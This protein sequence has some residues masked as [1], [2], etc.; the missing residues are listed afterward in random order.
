MKKPT[1]AAV[2]SAI[3]WG[4][5]QVYN[6]QWFKG[7]FFFLFQILLVGIE[8][9][10]GNYFSGAFSFRESGFFIKGL[11]GAITLG[12]QTST[13]TENG[14]TPGDHSDYVINPRDYLDCNFSRICY[15]LVHQY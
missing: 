12:T 4:S 14:L 8:L 11:W 5:G 7:A 13:L 15:H 3:V 1:L 10:T 2:L 6:K 9:L